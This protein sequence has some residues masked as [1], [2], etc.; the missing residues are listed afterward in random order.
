MAQTLATEDTGA[1][2][3]SFKAE[4]PSFPASKQARP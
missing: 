4:S 1:W 2:L 3:Y